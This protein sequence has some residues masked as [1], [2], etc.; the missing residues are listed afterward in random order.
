M[1]NFQVTIGY[2]AVLSISVKAESEEDA[3][4]KALKIMKEARTK[5]TT[6]KMALEDDSYKADGVINTD[7]TWN[8]L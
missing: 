8:M 1:A 6:G 2:K 3:K 4:D 5:L 7:N